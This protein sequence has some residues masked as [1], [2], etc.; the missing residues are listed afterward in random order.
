MGLKER[1]LLE[2]LESAKIQKAIRNICGLNE[3]LSTTTNNQTQ[4]NIMSYKNEITKL[5]EQLQHANSELETIKSKNGL[6]KNKVD[7]L[8][9]K[10]E[11][12]RSGSQKTLSEKHA[13]EKH[14]RDLNN[15]N[16]NLS[17]ELTSTHKLLENL[18]GA[19]EKPI[20]Y[21]NMYR[22]VSESV[23]DG[24]SDIICDKNEILFIASCTS[25]DNLRKIWEYTKEI[26]SIDEDNKQDDIDILKNIFDYFFEV[27]NNSLPEPI[28]KRDN[29]MID[30]E[31]DDEKHIRS[32]NSITSGYIKEIL[33][34]GYY[35]INTEKAICK[36]VVRI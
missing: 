6:L 26:I 18:K 27:Y 34:R 2:L 14:I 32:R 5:T 23:R 25:A 12:E 30:D 36:S 24:L 4:V 8:E 31:Y 33:L 11:N 29:V 3:H 22:R 7:E 28:Y 10:L 21:L 20:N 19:F 1:D 9:K 16:Q 15:T 17:S 13:L 35:S